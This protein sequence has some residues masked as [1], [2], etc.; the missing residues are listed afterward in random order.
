MKKFNIA[1]VIAVVTFILIVNMK[2]NNTDLIRLEN[3][4]ELEISPSDSGEIIKIQYATSLDDIIH[5]FDRINTTTPDGTYNDEE[6]I[7]FQVYT[8]TKGFYPEGPI[9]VAQN[10]MIFKNQVYALNDSDY[11]TL[12][13]LIN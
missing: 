11:N 4:E 12:V 6:E 1:I 5:I 2:G 9:S 13:Y 10:M 3:I 7:L 8:H